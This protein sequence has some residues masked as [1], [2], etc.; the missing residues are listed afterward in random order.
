MVTESKD[1]N[2]VRNTYGTLVKIIQEY[3]ILEITGFFEK[4]RQD[5]EGLGI[6]RFRVKKYLKTTPFKIAEIEILEDFQKSGGS[7]TSGKIA[8]NLNEEQI[9]ENSVYKKIVRKTYELIEMGGIPI[10]SIAERIFKMKR[11]GNANALLYLVCVALPISGKEKLRLLRFKNT[12]QRLTD[13]HRALSKSV[14]LLKQNRVPSKP[15]NRRP[16]S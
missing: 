2:G 3:K 9:H 14:A 4:V 15:S 1:E 7:E 12:K 5:L 8:E 13:V 10:L 6:I 16:L 11:E